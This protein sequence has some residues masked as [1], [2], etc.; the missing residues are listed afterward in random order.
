MFIGSMVTQGFQQLG[1]APNRHSHALCQRGCELAAALMLLEQ[2]LAIVFEDIQ[3]H[4]PSTCGNVP[5]TVTD[6]S[7]IVLIEASAEPPACYAGSVQS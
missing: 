5:A 4:S 1:E 3:N 6:V 2:E 7:I